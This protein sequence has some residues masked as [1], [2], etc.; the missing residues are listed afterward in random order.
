IRSS[1]TLMTI[2]FTSSGGAV[3]KGPVRKVSGAQ[4]KSR[5][6]VYEEKSSQHFFSVDNL[7]SVFL[8]FSA[9]P[10][11]W[12]VPQEVLGANEQEE[13]RAGVVE[14]WAERGG[15]FVRS[16]KLSDGQVG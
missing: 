12:N 11:H 4:K 2:Y 3:R 15:V 13:T 14:T 5:G 7:I 1:L 8:R 6:A 9:R 10:L 16:V